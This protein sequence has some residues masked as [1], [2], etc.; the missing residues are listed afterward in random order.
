MRLLLRRSTGLPS[1]VSGHRVLTIFSPSFLRSYRKYLPGRQQYY[2]ARGDYYHYSQDTFPTRKDDE[3]QQRLSEE[4]KRERD[5]AREKEKKKKRRRKQ[6]K[7][8]RLEVEARSEAAA[9]N[10]RQKEGAEI[11]GAIVL[12][13][14]ERRAEE[15][16]QQKVDPPHGVANSFLRLQQTPTI[17][18]YHM[19]TT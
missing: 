13:D 1:S 10:T 8:A 15:A 3:E 14:K 9:K 7:R 12:A 17:N 16:V 5:K 11:D 19:P 4:A 18:F 2:Y 6:N